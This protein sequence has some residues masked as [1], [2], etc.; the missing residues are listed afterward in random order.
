MACHIYFTNTCILTYLT[1]SPYDLISNS[2]YCPLYNIRDMSLENL[3]LHQLIIPHLIFF[4]ILII[5]LLSIVLIPSRK[6]LSWSLMGAKRFISRLMPQF[7]TFLRICSTASIN[8]NFYHLSINTVPFPWKA[9]VNKSASVTTKGHRLILQVTLPSLI[10][11][12]TVQRVIHQKKLHHTLSDKKKLLTFNTLTSVCKISILFSTN[13][14]C[15]QW[16]FVW[17]TRASLSRWWLM[18][19][20]TQW[21]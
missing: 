21:W 16:E 11:D 9:V 20:I 14:R 12:G 15:W 8:L 1:Y 13:F 4:F 2:S 5:C 17:W 7:T 10:T 6:L 19:F 18:I 3:V